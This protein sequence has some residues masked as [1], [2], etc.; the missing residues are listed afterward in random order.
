MTAAGFPRWNTS[1]EP[2]QPGAAPGPNLC[3]SWSVGCSGAVQITGADVVR[4]SRCVADDALAVLRERGVPLG[5][6]L[7]TIPRACVEVIVPIGTAATWPALPYTR[8]VSAA[9]MR[10]PAPTLTGSF[11]PVDGRV[12]LTPPTA[13]AQASTD[14]DELT[15]AVAV[16]LVRH[17][18]R[19]TTSDAQ[20]SRTR[21][22][23]H[24]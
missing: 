17:A 8:C 1:E 4:I 16:A 15:E 7:L 13:D 12:W 5:P 10:L 18:V 9:V 19:C 11:P 22:E 20:P 21:E 2:W 14:A 6:V 23:Q 3:R 24:P